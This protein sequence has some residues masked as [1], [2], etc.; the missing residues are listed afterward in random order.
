MDAAAVDDVHAELDDENYAGHVSSQAVPT[1]I[2]RKKPSAANHKQIGARVESSQLEKDAKKSRPAVREPP[3]SKRDDIAASTHSTAPAL[4][5]LSDVKAGTKKT[6]LGGRLAR[7]VTSRND[8]RTDKPVGRSKSKAAV[9]APT[10]DAKRPTLLQDTAAL[11]S[12]DG[13]R[14]D[15]DESQSFLTKTPLVSTKRSKVLNCTDSAE[16]QASR[17][18]EPIDKS[19]TTHRGGGG[20]D[21]SVLHAEKTPIVAKRAAPAAG[22]NASLQPQ[23]QQKKKR[24]LLKGGGTN[25][26]GDF[27][28]WKGDAEVS[29]E[30]RTH[31]PRLSPLSNR[32]CLLPSLSHLQGALD[33]KLNLPFELS[34][35]KPGGAAA[36]AG[37]G[38][39]RRGGATGGGGGT[40]SV[41]GR[42]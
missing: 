42:R 35:I 40:L 7:P 36:T 18:A 22:V 11:S 16:E 23:Q 14:R 1:P 21:K 24:R 34:P 2:L 19:P 31:S 26:A 15:G 38:A 20:G 5:G 17:A 25:V 9:A 33:P 12:E 37:G 39:L 30:G 27:L 3:A 10:K 6:M 8:S 13:R 29:P 32:L 28:S 4:F 41:F